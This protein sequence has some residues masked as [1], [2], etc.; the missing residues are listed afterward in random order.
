MFCCKCYSFGYKCAI[1]AIRGGGIGWLAAGDIVVPPYCSECS[2]VL[3]ACAM[4]PFYLFYGSLRVSC[5]RPT[6]RCR[7][8]PFLVFASLFLLPFLLSFLSRFCLVFML[9]LEF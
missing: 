2:F 8:C 5:L 6:S 9:P 7:S 4:H 3:R 1:V